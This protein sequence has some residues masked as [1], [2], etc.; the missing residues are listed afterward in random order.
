[1]IAARE[2][3]SGVT[4]HLVDGSYD[5]GPIVDQTTVPV[6]SGDTTETLAARVLKSEHSFFSETL[7]RIISGDIDLDSL[8]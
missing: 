5:T 3:E 1:V 8:R 4:V 2:T 7:A 6:E